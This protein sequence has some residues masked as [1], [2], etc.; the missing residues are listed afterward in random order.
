MTATQLTIKTNNQPKQPMSGL[1]LEL[2]V[3][4]KQAAQ[5]RK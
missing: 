3:G 2:F 5:I 4:D 1:T